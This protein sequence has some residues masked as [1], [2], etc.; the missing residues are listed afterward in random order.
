[1]LGRKKVLAFFS[2]R[3]EINKKEEKKIN[4]FVGKHQN[5][6]CILFSI[7]VAIYKTALRL[8][9]VNSN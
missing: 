3:K 2:T 6:V 7:F 9:L 8:Q 5:H 1:M 4:E